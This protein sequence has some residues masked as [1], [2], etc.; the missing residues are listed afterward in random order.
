MIN[1]KMEEKK[2]VST[3]KFSLVGTTSFLCLDFVRPPN[4][5]PV[6]WVDL[7]WLPGRHHT[8]LSFPFLYRT[9]GEIKMEKVMG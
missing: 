7:T 8:S 9:E 2:I 4:V 1:D 3:R 6:W 5:K